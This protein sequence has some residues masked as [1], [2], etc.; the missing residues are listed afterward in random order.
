MICGGDIDGSISGLAAC[1]SGGAET[2]LR[3]M[4]WVQ[5]FVNS[6]S[7]KRDIE[8]DRKVIT[9][10]RK[11]VSQRRPDII[12]ERSA[13]LHKAGLLAAR[14]IGVPYVLEWKDHLIP[15]SL[16]LYHRKAV[17]TERQKNE[18][19]DFIVVESNK[20]KNDLAG[21]GVKS[22]KIIV[23]HNAINPQDFKIDVNSRR[24]YRDKWNIKDNQVLAGYLG[25]YNFY[26]DAVR[27]VLASDILRTQGRT[28]IKIIMVGSGKEYNQSRNLAEKK[29]L[30][31]TMLDMKPW[32]PSKEVPGILSALDIAVLP[33]ST[34]IICP[35]KVQE[36]MAL[37]LPT[38][39][40]DYPCNREVITDGQTGLFFEPKNER[41][42]AEKLGNLA[43]NAE[44][45]K[46]IGNIAAANVLQRFTWEKTWGWALQEIFRRL[47]KI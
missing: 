37:G 13:R 10:A 11:M 9:A 32:A 4:K 30:L 22:D 6:I 26:H 35:I 3:Q 1:E 20:L 29:K 40:P 15:Y 14:E 42:L 39:L 2:G 44:L 38:V 41:S 46:K 17:E 34:D 36:Y 12:W 19:A 16:S 25:S 43:S 45:R 5:P 27:L 23:A 7:E 33:G 31:G 28:D 8:H 47:G 24:Q 18:S 21:D